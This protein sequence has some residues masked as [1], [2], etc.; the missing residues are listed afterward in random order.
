MSAPQSPAWSSSDHRD[1]F[2]DALRGTSALAVM[3]YHFNVGSYYPELTH[4]RRLTSYGYLGVAVFFV[5]SG[6]CIGKSWLKSPGTGAFLGQRF[7]RIYPAYAASLGFIIL[8]ALVRKQF[9]GTNDVARIP[10]T[11]ASILAVLTLSTEPASTVPTMNRVYW[12]LTYEVFFYLVMGLVLCVPTIIRQRQALLGV[13]GAFCALALSGVSFTGTPLFFVNDWNFFAMGMGVCLVSVRAPE[14]L[15]FLSISGVTLAANAALGRL[16]PYDWAAMA[17][18]FLLLLPHRYIA[19]HPL[20]FL[21][22][23]SYSLYLLHV[24][25]ALYVFLRLV[26]PLIGESR[27]RFALMQ[28]VAAALVIA[29]A[30][31]FHRVFEKP[32]LHRRTQVVPA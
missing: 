20:V 15:W 19:P 23:I 18:V 24:P 12:S 11:P 28:A 6:Y 10:T 30:T 25:V 21:G 2:I 5:I 1:R 7:R 14:A 13:H 26:R 4:W 22:R 16:G 17:S 29:A 3:L 27:P 32:F 31:L 8:C 9:G